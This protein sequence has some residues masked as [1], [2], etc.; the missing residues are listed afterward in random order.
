[1]AEP[2]TNA[3]DL[4]DRITIQQYAEDQSLSTGEMRYDNDAWPNEA[5]TWADVETLSGRD[6]VMVQQSGYVASHRVR[7]RFRNGIKEKTTRFIHKGVRLY[8]VHP[9][10]VGGRN[11]QLE[12]LCRS[13]E[14]TAEQ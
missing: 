11:R 10:N 7:M 12:I 6:Y 4:R 2:L 13:D 8:V 9:N 5:E 1:M 14:S 3:A